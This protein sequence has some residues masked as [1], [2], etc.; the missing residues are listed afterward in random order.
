MMIKWK[1]IAKFACGAEAFHA[2]IH[3]VLC[4][5]GTTITVFGITATPT[6]NIVGAVVNGIV[7]LLLG[8]YAWGP[9][10]RQST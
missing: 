10:G 5:S 2:L 9:F 7:S 8:I 1:E 6:W 3:A 4:F